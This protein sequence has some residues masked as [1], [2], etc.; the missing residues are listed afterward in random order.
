[1]IGVRRLLALELIHRER[2]L[3]ELGVDHQHP[4]QTGR[5]QR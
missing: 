5:K 2:A 4:D 3:R 1:L